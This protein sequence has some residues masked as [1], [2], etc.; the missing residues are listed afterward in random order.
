MAMLLLL[1]VIRF[2]P[3]PLI[4]SKMSEVAARSGVELRF[5]QMSIFGWY[6]GFSNV[7]VASARLPA[8][9][10]IDHVEISPVWSSLLAGKGGVH[11]DL[12]WQGVHAT[13]TI[14]QTGELISIQG[15]EMQA[16]MGAL[17]GALEPFLRLSMPVTVSGRISMEGDVMLQR[18][19]G[20]PESGMLNAS[21]QGAKAGIMGAEVALGDLSFQLQSKSGQWQWLVNDGDTGAIDAHGDVQEQGA[22]MAGWPLTGSAVIDV[23]K[24]N[25]PTL[26]AWLPDSGGGHEVRLNVFGTLS[27]PGLDIVK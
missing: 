2:D 18:A 22:Q 24:I 14:V 1:V 5:D 12:L 19:S 3:E 21:W 20:L 25:D 8:P 4:R 11:V 16:D 7:A 27:R 17:A 6:A 23:A 13:A 15:M 10:V 26:L 9:L